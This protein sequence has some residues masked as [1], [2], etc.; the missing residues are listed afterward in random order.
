MLHWL[1]SNVVSVV[2]LLAVNVQEAPGE[3]SAP[4]E[5]W[6]EVA[7]AYEPA[8]EAWA[9]ARMRAGNWNDPEAE[10]SPAL[11]FQDRFEAVAETGD[12]RALL[13]LLQNPQGEGEVRAERVRRA[14][15]RLRAAGDA[16]WLPA[17]LGIL[18][19]LEPSLGRET[20][21]AFLE[22]H[23]KEPH[24]AST[25][26]AALLARAAVLASADP[27]LAEHLRRR[28]V[29]VRWMDAD[30]GDEDSLTPEDA[31]EAAVAALATLEEAG[32]AWLTD[33]MFEGSDGV[34]YPRADF[35][36]DPGDAWAPALQVLAKDGAPAACAHELF[37]GRD[38]GPGSAER[39]RGY[40]E[41]MLA[42][43]LDD[44][45]RKQLGYNLR[46]LM[47]ELGAEFIETRVGPLLDSSSEE[48]RR[49]LLYGLGDGLCQ[50]GG[51]AR[52]RGLAIL[53]EVEAKWPESY[54]GQ[55]AG[56]RIFRHTNLVVGQPVP[57]FE[58][59]D[60]DGHAF[61]LSDYRGKVTVIDFWGFW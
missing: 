20:L 31:Q 33:N 56:G 2:A 41:R 16:D 30:L 3:A 8:F 49:G 15:A 47:G 24:P 10:P 32:R 45:T 60:A 25:R 19:E 14:F 7:A 38:R 54:E 29:F 44:G 61:R 48:Q 22:E 26:A 11:A 46:Y 36:P 12:A 6:E 40:L 21:V 55:R 4:P 37:E 43:P 42:A 39:R 13:W 58:A 53:R 9:A 28:A 23:A 5:T 51:E 34:Y 18:P 52:E 35:R 27:A 50:A 57:D 17:A 1:G 59:E